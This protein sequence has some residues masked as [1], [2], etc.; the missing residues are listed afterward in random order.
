MKKHELLKHAYDNYPKGLKI[1]WPIDTNPVVFECSGSYLFM[2]NEGD[3]MIVDSVDNELALWNGKQWAEIVNPK[4]AVKVE[5]EKEFKALM[6]YYDSLGYSNQYM[7]VTFPE[8]RIKEDGFLLITFEDNYVYP[9]VYFGNHENLNPDNYQIIPFSE[10]AVERGIKLPHITTHDGVNLY[11]GDYLACVWKQ[12][13]EWVLTREYSSINS[14][15]V[16]EAG[17]SSLEGER[18]L[19]STEQAALDWIEAQKPKEIQ[20]V[21]E[22]GIKCQIYKEETI[23]N[24]DCGCFSITKKD[25]EEI[26]N[27]IKELQ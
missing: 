9:H 19:F 22:F 15:T 20:Y 17:Q 6:K 27:R 8:K 11:I 24:C 23:L 12:Q 7:F 26:S 16:S 5:N 25:I 10:F 21:S 4:I 14:T 13:G 1:T 2:C 18:K 3:E